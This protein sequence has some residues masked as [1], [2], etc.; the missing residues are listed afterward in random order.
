MTFI[1]VN[2]NNFGIK[3]RSK[4]KDIRSKQHMMQSSAREY[5]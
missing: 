3:K 1:E 5:R 2:E 4:K